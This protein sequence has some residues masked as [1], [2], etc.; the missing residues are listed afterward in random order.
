[1][2][3]VPVDY[4]ADAIFTL[5]GAPEAEGGTYHLTASEQATSV[6]ELVELATTRFARPAPRLIEPRLYRR[7][8]HPLLVRT[9]RDE[10]RRRALKRSEAFFPYFAMSVTYDDRRSRAALGAAGLEPP[11]LNRYFDRLVEYALEADWGRQPKGRASTRRRV[12]RS[13]AI[14]SARRSRTRA[15]TPRRATRAADTPRRAAHR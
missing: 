8:V 3:I 2:D 12:A 9:S 4:V 1:V 6:G 5:T 15:D 13:A 10:R 11:P 14:A 7:L